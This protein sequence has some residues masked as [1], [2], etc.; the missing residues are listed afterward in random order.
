MKH[1]TYIKMKERRLRPIKL[2]VAIYEK[3]IFLSK[4]W[5]K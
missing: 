5:E 4:Y 2:Q 1:R 3:L